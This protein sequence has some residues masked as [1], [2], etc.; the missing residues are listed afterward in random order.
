MN[1]LFIGDVVGK[2]G[3]RAVSTLVPRLR[4]IVQAL[5]HNR[6]EVTYAEIEAPHGHDAF[7]LDDPRYHAVLRA[8]FDNV[9]GDLRAGG[10]AAPKPARIPSGDRPTYPSDEGLS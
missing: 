4:E 1:I 7:L 10:R 2:P 5:L 8:C 6:R 3:R 9:A